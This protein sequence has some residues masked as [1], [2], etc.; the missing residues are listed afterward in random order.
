MRTG[1]QRGIPPLLALFL[2]LAPPAAAEYLVTCAFDSETLTAGEL[3]YGIAHDPGPI[4]F[5]QTEFPPGSPTVITLH[6]ARGP[7]LIESNHLEIDGTGGGQGTGDVVVDGN[8]QTV[9][10]IAADGCAIRGLGIR[11]GLCGIEVDGLDAA[12]GSET[13]PNE[14]FSNLSHGILVTS[15]FSTLIRG[16]FIGVRLDG[17]AAGNGGDGIRDEG[18]V[19]DRIGGAGAERNCIGANSG[20][21]IAINP[22]L[23]GAGGVLVRNNYVG[24]APDGSSARPNALGG[25]YV[26]ASA[27]NEIGG[28]Q[29]AG[30]GNLVSGNSAGAGVEFAGCTSG[31]NLVL[32]NSIGTDAAG[33]AARPNQ[34]GVRISD[35]G[36]VE[37]GDSSDTGNL[38][39]G[40]ASWGIRITQSDDSLALSRLNRV[41]FSVVGLAANGSALGNGTAA[42]SDGGILIEAGARENQVGGTS[43]GEGNVISGNVGCGVR[44]A[45]GAANRLEGNRIGTDAAGAAA[46]GNSR[47]GVFIEG[48]EGVGWAAES[49]V[50]GGGDSYYLNVISG[51]AGAG[52]RIEGTAA[53][54][55]QIAGNAIGT[56][57]GGTARLPN[58]EG[59]IAIAGGAC[60]NLVASN[61]IAFNGQSGSGDG[62]R[63]EGAG[64]DYN[65][66][67][68]NSLRENAGLGI[69]LS[70]GAN[71]SAAA[72]AIAA[73]TWLSDT[74]ARVAGTKSPGSSLELFAADTDAAGPGEG[75]SLLAA[76]PPDGEGEW[77]IETLS[78]LA[79][80]EWLTADA[81]TA[82]GSTSEFSANLPFAVESPSPTP[83]PSVTPTPPTPTP[84]ASPTATATPTPSPTVPPSPTPSPTAKLPEAVYVFDFQTDPGWSTESDWAFGVPLGQGGC[85]APTPEEG[86]GDSYG[87]PDPSSGCTGENVYGYNLAG[88][89]PD[90]L[91]ATYYLT[92]APLDLSR[93]QGTYL[94]FRR[95]L[96]VEQA[97][98]DHAYVQASTDGTTWTVLW[99]NPAGPGEA[100]LDAAWNDLSY[101]LAPIYDRA[102]ALRLR[103]GMGRTDN[104]RR[105]SGWN[106]DDVEIWGIL[107]PSPSPTPRVITP[108][109]TATPTP[110]PLP[111]P[112]PSPSSS[113]SPAP[114]PSSSPS[115]P[116][117][118]PT[119]GR[120]PSPSPSPA[121]RAGDTFDWPFPASLS[122]QTE[123]DTTGFYDQYRQYSCYPYALE[124][125][126]D[127]VYAFTTEAGTIKVA[128][129]AFS[130]D[131]DLFLCDGPNRND[132][133]AKSTYGYM[134]EI[135]YPAAPGT[136]YLVVDGFQ[137]A[138]S[139]YRLEIA[140]AAATRRILQSG[141]YDGD[142]TAEIAVFRPA[143]GLWSVRELTRAYLGNSLDQPAP[144]DYDGD[145]TADPAIFR[146][147]A[148]LWSIRSITR[149]YFG[150][151]LDLPAPADYDGD[152]RCEIAG[153]RAEASLWSIRSLT[154]I[155]FGSS[156]DQAVPA[157]YDGDGT[158]EAAIY[159]PLPGLWASRD[160]FRAYFGVASDLPLPADYDG[161]GRDRA[162]IFRPGQ[163]MWGV[164]ELTRLYFGAEGDELVPAD[165]DGDGVDDPGIF[166][167][168][169]GLWGARLVT[170]AY[171]GTAGDIPV[172]R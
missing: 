92:T 145:G 45:R 15:G 79:L 63:L 125:G 61:R 130:G 108:T 162:A 163:G 20:Y 147:E 172:T 103:W 62:C 16:N 81:S 76:L 134:E 102:S 67:S 72:P 80:G 105:Y 8:G 135:E 78:G 49:N 22:G 42:E 75:F 55:N 156:D 71:E 54:R 4:F 10:R 155:Y 117:P 56:D 38:V 18:G 149:V 51:N 151:S 109:P 27:E 128:L 143:D 104:I 168:A 46:I 129:E 36:G 59:G 97:A 137:G 7:L 19:G 13:A 32:G 115:R 139:D 101:N 123:A 113:P 116:P 6:P 126:P 57:P 99:A 3:R 132:C 141:D 170:R 89:Y 77:A 84:S 60:G 29:A 26:R 33:L 166:R 1:C 83:T 161:A 171:F 50:V 148:S 153:F 82:L 12:I 87:N 73:V 31:P 14:I 118:T 154:R 86:C 44:I 164:A 39:S 35:S 69:A 120:S 119:P 140:F 47:H 9:F 95:W 152:G 11:N 88:D 165:Y 91:P 160:G 111:S 146:P 17:T 52:I 93:A 157:D 121:P 68:A 122:F 136:Y 48:A 100:V 24:L 40:N 167:S 144:G 159:R 133:V 158:D 65:L 53:R 98:N 90:N 23:G 64:T 114:T 2:W 96:N 28:S 127:V 106:L 41:R 124:S 34:W 30:W 107:D 112:S 142:G 150:S 43:P 70:G 37:V 138:Q 94:R 25:V 66:V 110:T 21:G 131:L 85:P 169:D 58:L 5:S 74:S